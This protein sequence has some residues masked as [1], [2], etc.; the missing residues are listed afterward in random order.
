MGAQEN[1]MKP[2]Q[3]KVSQ[4]QHQL[5]NGQLEMSQPE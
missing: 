4:F 1:G 5:S 2:Y 3:P